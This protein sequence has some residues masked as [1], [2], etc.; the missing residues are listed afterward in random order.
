MGEKKK[1]VV[2]STAIGSHVVVLLDEPFDGLDVAGKR[3]MHS[4]IKSLES[5]ERVLILTTNCVKDA[6]KISDW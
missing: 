6:S 1:V 4:F 2:G 3:K 5:Q